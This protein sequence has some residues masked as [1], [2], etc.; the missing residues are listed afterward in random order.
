[1]EAY[2]SGPEAFWEAAGLC[3]AG[4][5]SSQQSFGS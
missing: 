1:M 5:I 2:T 4:K 3:S